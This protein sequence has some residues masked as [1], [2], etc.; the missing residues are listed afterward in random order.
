M[1]NIGPGDAGAAFET[2]CERGRNH[3]PNAVIEGVVVAPM[4]DGGVET[5]IGVKRDPIFGPVVVFGLGGVFV[6]VLQDVSH[7]LAPF[8]V[9]EAHEMIREVKGYPLLE[10][11]RGGSVADIDAL[12]EAL[13][14]LSVFGYQ[15]R[16]R[17]DSI[18]INP[19]I[20][21]PE[22]QGACAVD[23]LIIP[24]SNS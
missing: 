2:L 14:K 13:S 15:N 20:V 24:V 9:D 6:E 3:K 18:D 4:I 21:L 12:A 11:V 5:I 10:G 1:L 22:G 8:G 23:A 19:F 16:D 17:I 7:R